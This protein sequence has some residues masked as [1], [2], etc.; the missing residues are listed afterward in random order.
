MSGEGVIDMCTHPEAGMDQGFIEIKD[1]TLSS[2]MFRRYG[3]EQWFKL[4]IL[5][6]V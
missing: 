6:R 1:K 2:H 3:R 4:A 5:F